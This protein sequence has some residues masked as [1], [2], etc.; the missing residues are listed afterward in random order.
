MFQE[1]IVSSSQGKSIKTSDKLLILRNLSDYKIFA[2]DQGEKDYYNIYTTSSKYVPQ[3]AGPSEFII[4][5]YR[6]ITNSYVGAA[7]SLLYLHNETVNFY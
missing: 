4:K 7:K 1:T 3:W 2:N 5:G 6:R